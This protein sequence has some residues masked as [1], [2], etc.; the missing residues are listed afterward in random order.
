MIMIKRKWFFILPAWGLNKCCGCY[1]ANHSPCPMA[2]EK[3]NCAGCI[4]IPTDNPPEEATAALTALRLGAEVEYE[5][6][7]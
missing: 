6:K 2:A 5:T 3:W 4:F 1:F 7:T